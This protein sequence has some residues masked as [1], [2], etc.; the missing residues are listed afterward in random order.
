[1]LSSASDYYDRV[2]AASDFL[3]DRLGTVPEVGVVLGSGLGGFAEDMDG[4]VVIP[5]GEIPN[6]PAAAVIGHAG[7]LVGGVVSGR[8]VVA[9]SGRAHFYEG[10]DMA[11]V[12]FGVR[13]LGRLGVRVVI[14]TN[15]AGGVNTSFRPASLMLIDDHINLFGTN[16]LLGPN[17]ERF[18]PRFPD[19]TEVY[20]RRLRR[21]A[22]DAAAERG[23]ALVHG[24]YA[25][26][27]G[28]SYE[29]PA[30][31]RYLRGI[32]ADAVGMSTVPEAIAA[33][34]MGVDVLGI[35]CITNMAAGVLDKPL[36]HDE[37]MATAARVGDEF[38][39]LLRGIIA[40]LYEA[41]AP[42]AEE[43]PRAD[44]THLI[45]AARAARERAWAPFSRFEVG[46]ALETEDG[47]VVTG[48]NIENATYG[49]TLCAER[50]AM[51]KAVSEGH[52]RF[53][54]IVVVADT[55]SPTAPCGPCRQI[56]WEFGGDLEVIMANLQG[57]TARHRLKE[58]LPLPFDA[59]L[60]EED[61]STWQIRSGSPRS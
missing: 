26:L 49:L 53:T 32:G 15:A 56:L 38:I 7:K 22:E 57:Q 25:G 11:T 34:H 30:E 5:Y 12:C 23:I 43:Q 16:P 17:D 44:V 4:A 36:H 48:C 39:A 24:V 61:P 9:L 54:R 6:W 42:M 28:P 40:R 45:D 51:F 29:T 52:R 31:I 20:S 58:L 8:R 60:L 14:L 41:E 50:V 13:A 37:V 59:R 2:T 3:R 18:G 27:H 47:T 35:S 46:A 21:I 55:A 33:R 1:V 19:M 10:H